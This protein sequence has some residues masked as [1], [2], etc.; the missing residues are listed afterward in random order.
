M[1]RI[2]TIKDIP[3]SSWERLAHKRIFF[4]HQSVGFDIV[5]GIEDLLK[6]NSLPLLKITET[7]ILSDSVE[8]VFAHCRLGKNGDPEFK[9]VDFARFLEEGGGNRADMAFLKFCYVDV[10]TRTDVN[11]LFT[12][13]KEMM[14]SLREKYPR[15]IFIHFS[16]PVTA[17][18]NDFKGRIKRFF[19]LSSGE[20]R[21]NIKRNQFNEKL[22]KEY[23]TEKTLFDLAELQ[24][25]FPDGSKA[26][27]K[28]GNKMYPCLVPD[29]TNDGGHLNAKG[30]KRVAEQ[31]LVFLASHL[32]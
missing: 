12:Q 23:R 11:R 7:N 16:V 31:L 30:R 4:A 2:A 9:C 20:Q 8:P 1:T 29:Y 14:S 25:T 28:N 32:K 17:T 27:F 26:F 13:Y 18:P 22:R 6:E 3:T 10:T 24:S 15:M 21:D 5:A 19:G